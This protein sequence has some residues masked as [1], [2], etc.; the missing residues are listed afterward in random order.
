MIVKVVITLGV[1]RAFDGT[2]PWTREQSL[3]SYI[4]HWL[5]EGYYIEDYSVNLPNG[6]VYKGY[7]IELPKKWRE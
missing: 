6:I 3:D 7:E 2:P 5:E 4:S 1:P